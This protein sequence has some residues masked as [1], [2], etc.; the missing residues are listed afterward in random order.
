MMNC[1]PEAGW[2][3]S[4]IGRDLKKVRNVKPL[5]SKFGTWIGVPLGWLKLASP[6]HPGNLRLAACRQAFMDQARKSNPRPLRLSRR[7]QSGR[8]LEAQDR[9][10][11]RTSR[12]GAVLSYRPAGHRMIAEAG[13]DLRSQ[14]RLH[15]FE[16]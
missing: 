14:S 7:T 16:G 3:G 1:R 5:W 8:K 6:S 4:E 11:K 12:A 9:G 2:R 10:A 13:A 15:N